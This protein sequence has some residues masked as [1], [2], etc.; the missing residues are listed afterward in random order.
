MTRQYNN[1]GHDQ[2]NIENLQVT[3]STNGQELFKKGL[4]LLNQ[5]NYQ[6]AIDVLNEATEADPSISDAHY[7]LA[8]ALLRGKKP[9]KIDGWTIRDIEEKLNAAIS[10]D[11][12][13]S[14]CYMLWAIIKHGYYTMNCLIE[15]S[16][17]SEQLFSYGK[18]IQPKYAKEIIYH[19]N[20]PSNKYWQYLYNK[21]A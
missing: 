18:S 3:P 16:P 20:D 10:E 8:I 6:Q 15:K 13:S 19:L 14:K 1:Y 11:A 17:T 7:Y 21:F 12:N 9:N 5:R 4:K 2:F